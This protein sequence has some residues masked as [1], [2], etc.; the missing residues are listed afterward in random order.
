[1]KKEELLGTFQKIAEQFYF[2]FNDEKTRIAVIQKF[3]DFI[4]QLQAEGKLTY[5]LMKK[6]VDVSTPFMINQ[7]A[8][9]IKVELVDGRVITIDEYCEI[10]TD[11][12]KYSKLMYDLIM[13]FEPN[14]KEEKTELDCLIGKKLIKV[15]PA[16]GDEENSLDLIFDDGTILCVGNDFYLA[17]E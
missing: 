8:F 7:G 15:V 3:K 17:E 16:A 9:E 6:F 4:H 2:E 12:E 10:L 5:S 14:K 11:K 13:N 1:M